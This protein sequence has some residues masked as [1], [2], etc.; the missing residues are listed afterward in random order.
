MSLNVSSP[1]HMMGSRRC[2]EDTVRRD[3]D[4]GKEALMPRV[5]AQHLCFAVR[6]GFQALSDLGVT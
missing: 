3:A 4:M 6:R 2:S 5:A 1:E